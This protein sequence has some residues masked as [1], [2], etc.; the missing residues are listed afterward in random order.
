MDSMKFINKRNVESILPLNSMQE[1]MLYHYLQDTTNQLY[2]E[3]L[4]ISLS[5]YINIEIIKKAWEYVVDTNEALRSIFRWDKLE[6]PLQ[7]ILK[8]KLVLIKEVSFVDINPVDRE[9]A[10]RQLKL[11]DRNDKLNITMDP[12]RITLCEIDKENCIMII[13]NH[14][15]LYDGWSNSILLQEFFLA[16]NSLIVG[17]T[18]VMPYKNTLNKCILHRKNNDEVKKYWKSYFVDYTADGN[19]PIGKLTETTNKQ[20]CCNLSNLLCNQIFSCSKARKKTLAVLFYAAWGIL[21]QRYMNCK[22]VVFGTTTSGRDI[23][24]EHIDKMVGLF[25]QTPPLRICYK[26][27]QKVSSFLEDIEIMLR[28]RQEYEDTPITDIKKWC[29]INTNESLFD[30]IVVIENYPLEKEIAQSQGLLNVKS[31]EMKENTNFGIT[32]TVEVINQNIKL[33]CNIDTGKITEIIGERILDHLINILTQITNTAD[34]QLEDIDMLTDKEKRTLSDFNLPFVKYHADRTIKEIFENQVDNTPD[35]VALIYED[36][37]MTYRE[38]NNKAN[39]LA[40]RLRE[41]GVKPNDRVV[42]MTERGFELLIAI[43]GVIKAGG[44]YVPIDS[45]NPKE[46]ISFI[47]DD[48]TPKVILKGKEK[49]SV[50]SD[51]PVINLYDKSIYSGIEKNLS[52]VNKPSDILYIFYTSGT[53]GHPKGVIVEH[54]NV[55]Q[56]ITNNFN[57]DINETDIWLFSHSYCFDVSI[58]EIFGA[59]LFGAKLVI[60]SNEGIRDAYQMLNNIEKYGVTILNQVP[61]VFFSLMNIDDGKFGSV[62]YLMLSGEELNS[63]K[64]TDWHENYPALKI[65]NMYGPTETTIFVTYREVDK[66]LEERGISDIGSAIPTIGILIL[67][68]NQLC[69]IGLPGEICI[70]GAG[71][72]RGYLN[73]PKLTKEKFVPNPFGEGIMYRTGDQ[74]R[75]QLDGNIEYL[76]RLDDQ[77]KIRGFRIDLGE[78]EATLLRHPIVKDAVALVKNKADDIKYICAYVTISGSVC[79]DDLRAYLMDKL[80]N[81]MVPA[82]F[83]ILEKIPLTANGKKDKKAL[84]AIHET[85]N[86]L[87]IRVGLEPKDELQERLVQIWIDLLKIDYIT[88]DDNFF[89]I[90]GDS[91]LAVKLVARIHKIL[92]YDFTVREVFNNPTVRLMANYLHNQD[93][94]MSQES[95]Y[96]K[97]IEERKLSNDIFNKNPYADYPASSTQKRLYALWL[98]NKESTSYNMPVAFLIEGRIDLVRF[99]NSFKLLIKRH[100]ILRSSFEIDVNDITQRVHQEVPFS[101]SYRK[102]DNTEITTMVQSLIRPFNLN[103]APLMRAELIEFDN[104]KQIFFFDMHH[105]ISDEESL[106]I[107]IKDFI[108]YYSGEK[109]QDLRIQ[110]RDYTLWQQETLKKEILKSHWD[111]WKATLEPKIPLLNLPYDYAR[112]SIQSFAGSSVAFEIDAPLIIEIKKLTK[113]YDVTLFM[114]LIS[115]YQI[116]LSKYS[117]QDDVLV[118]FPVLGRAHPDT[119]D[120]IGMFAS[121]IVLRG[122]LVAKKTFIE[123]LKEI[124]ESSLDAVQY[125]DIP[126]E[127]LVDTFQPIRQPSRNPL[128]DVMF[129]MQTTVI[130]EFEFDKLR[131]SKIT[132]ENNISKFDLTMFVNESPEKLQCSIEYCTDLFSERTIYGIISCYTTILEQVLKKPH[133]KLSD[134]ELLNSNE[135]NIILNQLN[136]F[137]IDKRHHNLTIHQLFEKQA[138]L[139]PRNTALIYNGVRLDYKCLNEWANQIAWYLIKLDIRPEM[140]VAVEVGRSL[141]VI[142][143]ILGIMKAGC[144]YLPVIAEQPKERLFFMLKDSGV[145]VIISD[146]ENIVYGYKNQI[147]VVSFNDQNI[148][149][150]EVK[151]PENRS[152]KGSPAYVIYTSGTTGQP[153]GIII[154]HGAIMNTLLW[155]LKYYDY[156]EKD[157]VLILDS[158]AFDNS[159]EDTLSPLLA[160]ACIVI[161]SAEKKLEL[162]YIGQLLDEYSITRFTTVPSFY[163]VLLENVYTKM[164]CLRTVVVAGENCPQD[165]VEKHFKLLNHVKLFNEYG[166]TENSVCTTVYEFDSLHTNV[167]IGKPI[168]NTR[169]YVLNEYK[170]LQPIGVPG[171]LYISGTGLARGYINNPELTEKSFLPDIYNPLTKMYKTGDLVKWHPDGN[172][173]FIGRIDHQIKIRGFRIEPTEIEA[174]FYKYTDIEQVVVVPYQ[175]NEENIYLCAYFVSKREYLMNELK[176]LLEKV[177]PNYMI[178]SY[179]IQLDKIPKTLNGKIDVKAL[180]LPTVDSGCDK[181]IIYPSNE[182][183]IKLVELWKDILNISNISVEDNFF[184]L[185]GHSLKAAILCTRIHKELSVEISI[186]QLFENSTISKLA[187]L[188]KQ[189]VR[190]NYDAIYPTEQRLNYPMSSSQKR[191][192][193]LSQYKGV[194][195]AYNTYSVIKIYGQVDKEKF[196]DIFKSLILRHDVLRTAFIMVDNQPTQVIMQNID[197]HMEVVEG[198]PD[199]IDNI[200]KNVIRPFDLSIPS[201]CR[202]TLILLSNNESLLVIDMH[203]I[204]SD[205]V[206]IG[207]LINEFIQLYEGKQLHP[208]KIQYKDYSQWQNDAFTSEKI[209]LQEQYWLKVMSLPVPTLNMPT[210]YQ[211]P[212]LKNFKGE[213]LVFKADKELKRCLYD[214][215]TKTDSTLFMV[216][217][218]AYNA[219]LWIY[220]AQEDIIVGTPTANRNNADLE[221]MVGMFVNTI[222]LRNFPNA[223][224][225]FIDFLVEVRNSTLL[226]LDNQDY[227][228]ETLVD[229]LKSVR[230]M[231]RNPLYDTMFILQNTYIPQ[232]VKLGEISFR[233]YEYDDKTVKLDFRLEAIEEDDIRFRFAYC[234][235]LFK[236]DTMLEFCN[237]YLKILQKVTDNEEIKLKDLKNLFDDK[238]K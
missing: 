120:V 41:I 22:D 147:R 152:F 60:L 61:S 18:P 174:Q 226:A 50:T 93:K 131:F 29:G 32:L 150:Q 154:E 206:S 94:E 176:G 215:T 127:E 96:I 201:L 4:S 52:H 185:G 31:Y 187:L 235:K 122:H 46:R 26:K 207:I 228:F 118:G 57:F 108:K 5:G 162:S 214:L 173:E 223:N 90:G 9:E 175:P 13:S 116:L 70:V 55:M 212:W 102:I 8:R 12:F 34:I 14:H 159:L 237:R 38:L 51:L 190:N 21:L 136:S 145:E 139:M 210:D 129:V 25:I 171:E 104:N 169:C 209:R 23:E 200:L 64:L 182:I 220:T 99:E 165:L 196:E 157:V 47:I 112:P 1:G 56:L 80:P 160:G 193:T 19:L 67:N 100:E 33:S 205:G 65:F 74:G 2:F 10:L 24:I 7:I 151:N 132:F 211:R 191:M 126:F 20:Y 98:G 35:N 184:A 43:F 62:R 105:I 97:K 36:Q 156:N 199:E 155:N 85:N 141:G 202:I 83:I 106:S 69:G 195:T 194:G 114:F 87:P 92:E 79:V 163:K 222:P 125:Q 16:Y 78:I 233:E 179:F 53:T 133:I 172:L 217:F 124:K 3:Q 166:P 103:M 101:L 91:L 48:C 58:W 59:T 236:R 123:F 117:G 227:P 219:L 204:I 71:V 161:P 138:S 183:E 137:V 158:L 216:L 224:K 142:P 66:K 72:S 168:D 17:K 119:Q 86:V 110:Y 208:L 213:T 170:K 82:Y 113:K 115:I 144:A 232:K 75:W 229:K 148:Q 221:N 197:F 39:Q 63:K 177:L 49:L 40:Y 146:S 181:E 54:R 218:A 44:A 27:K 88:I 68:G 37:E 225:K 153:K 73:Q 238:K 135:K 130:D 230:E 15:I 140:V 111:Y 143:A 28:E 178:P 234:T 89:E 192:Y 186:K 167:L 81:F 11:N 128:F 30:S 198:T 42:I 164:N 45:V 77:I 188:I 84:L 149:K 203:H 231:G 107:L 134:I 109:L 189:L 121:T 6:Q 95:Y 76:G 180:P